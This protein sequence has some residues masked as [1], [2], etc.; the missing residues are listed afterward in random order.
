MLRKAF[1]ILP[2][3]LFSLL[4]LVLSSCDWLSSTA[5]INNPDYFAGEIEIMYVRVKEVVYPNYADPEGATILF[6][7]GGGKN[8]SNFI[9]MGE[10]KWYATVFLQTDP[11]PYFIV[12]IDMKVTGVYTCV[13]EKFL[14]RPKKE[15]AEWVELTCIVRSPL[16]IGGKAA[17]FVFSNDGQIRNPHRCL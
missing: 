2:L 15:G 16:S 13:G 3:I 4:V 10:N 6:P 8:S 14:L 17:K 11:N 12:T 9:S 5:P 1:L 7:T